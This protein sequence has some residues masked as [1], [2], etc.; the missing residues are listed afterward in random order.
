MAAGFSAVGM[1]LKSADQFEL[2]LRGALTRDVPVIIDMP[3]D[4]PEKDLITPLEYNL[5]E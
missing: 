2:M 4:Y 1:R 5:I 3:I